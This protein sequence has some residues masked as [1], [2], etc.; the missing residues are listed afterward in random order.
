M[1]HQTLNI[2]YWN[3]GSANMGLLYEKEKHGIIYDES[4]ST[5]VFVPFQ[6]LYI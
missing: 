4:D 1:I 6:F 2:V 5:N 3:V